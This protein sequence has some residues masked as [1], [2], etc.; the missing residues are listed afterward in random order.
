MNLKLPA[1]LPQPDA[2]LETAAHA[3]HSGGEGFVVGDEVRWVDGFHE[4]ECPRVPFPSRRIFAVAGEMMLRA[5]VLR[6]HQRLYESPLRTLFPA[7]RKRFLAG[8][9]RAADYAIETSGG[10]KYFTPHHGKPCMRKRHFP[11]TIDE[12]AREIWLRELWWAF[13][14]VGFP[15]QLREEYWDWVEPFSIRMINRRTQ[16]AQPRRHP[17]ADV[18]STLL[19][20]YETFAAPTLG[21]PKAVEKFPMRDETVRKAV[22]ETSS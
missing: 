21:A 17:F 7:D 5:L 15:P 2:R 1:D 20:G 13:D 19:Q 3:C 18:P 11:F 12:S 4:L 8:V 16:R 14:D 9:T 6:H 10:P 22:C